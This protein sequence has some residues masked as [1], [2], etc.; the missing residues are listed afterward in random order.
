[1]I[2]FRARAVHLGGWG[3]AMKQSEE[4]L[5]RFFEMTDG[6][7]RPYSLC[8]FRRQKDSFGLERSMSATET[9]AQARKAA[10]R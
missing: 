4:R 7:S 1:M 10:G 9:P 3:N 6:G 5:L 8:L 2:L